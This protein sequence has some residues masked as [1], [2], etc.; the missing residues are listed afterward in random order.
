MFCTQCSEK[1]IENLD[2]VSKLRETYKYTYEVSVK[3]MYDLFLEF[4]NEI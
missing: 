4:F 3:R 2:V 1:V